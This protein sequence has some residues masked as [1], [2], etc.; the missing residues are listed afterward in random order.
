ML[1]GED[2]LLVSLRGHGHIRPLMSLG[3]RLSGI[4]FGVHL[5]VVL[6]TK[7]DF[8]SSE[9]PSVRIL[10]MIVDSGDI[11]F[12]DWMCEYKGAILDWAIESVKGLKVLAV[13]YDAV[14]NWGPS[15]ASA[16]NVKRIASCSLGLH[17]Y[18]LWKKGKLFWQNEPS[19]GDVL[20]IVGLGDLQLR[21]LPKIT[22]YSDRYDEEIRSLFEGMRSM[23]TNDSVAEPGFTDLRKY[24][25][26]EV[27][28]DDGTYGKG[29]CYPLGYVSDWVSDTADVEQSWLDSQGENC[30][31]FVSL[32]SWVELSESDLIELSEGIAATG[33][34]FLW[35]LRERGALSDRTDKFGLPIG[36]RSRCTDRS[37]IVPWVNQIAVLRH[38]A[39]GLFITHC[40]WNGLTEGISLTPCPKAFLPCVGDQLINADIAEHLWRIGLS[41]WKCSVCDRHHVFEQINRLRDDP[42]FA[43]AANKIYTD[44]QHH[45]ATTALSS[46]DLLVRELLNEN[47]GPLAA[48]CT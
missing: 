44:H 8:P 47:V 23:I 18:Y 35:T 1:M 6:P 2:I 26:K 43:R 10:P 37:L 46:F 41:L 12:F 27:L 28:V 21:K 32:G 22:T 25:E 9:F 30:V 42:N 33:M 11:S 45:K 17:C 38:R 20:S 13:I 24:M 19:W 3:Q 34:P 36:F 29:H 15:L 31:I 4:G 5:L 7:I 14:V 39:V 48:Q 16:L 40:G